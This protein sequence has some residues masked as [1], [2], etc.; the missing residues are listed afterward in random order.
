MKKVLAPAVLLG[1]ATVAGGCAGPQ[2]LVPGE[3]GMADVQR[4]L[5]EPA[6]TWREPD[7]SQRLA[8]PR[9]PFGYHTWMVDLD[10][11]G[12]LRRV[13]NVLDEAH[14]A[15]VRPGMKHEQVL[16]ALGPSDPSG[17]AYYAA[18]DELAW[19]WRYCDNWNTAQRFNVLFDASQGT[20][21][22]TVTVP[23][24]CR[25]WSCACSR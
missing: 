20:V 8:Y 10:P 22:S 5:G 15:A 25:E 4:V 2:S 12:K 6:L 14:F 11:K 7:G 21:R 23:V 19:E 9:G 17:T 18:R 16:K 1:L 24:W 13:E 3:A